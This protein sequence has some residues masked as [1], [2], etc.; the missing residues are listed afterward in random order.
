[1]RAVSPFD[2]TEEEDKPTADDDNRTFRTRLVVLWL[3]VN[4]V[5]CIAIGRLPA[6]HRTLYF[7]VLLWV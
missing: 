2:T 1:M 3:L 6:V 5:L 4:A 7:Q